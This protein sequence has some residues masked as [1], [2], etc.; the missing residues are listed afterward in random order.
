MIRTFDCSTGEERWRYQ[1][2]AGVH[3]APAIAGDMLFVTAGS[4]LS[5]GDGTPRAELFTFRIDGT[6]GGA[7]PAASPVSSLPAPG[8]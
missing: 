2:D 3:A 4:G 7:A 1:A 5:G 6:H 8:A